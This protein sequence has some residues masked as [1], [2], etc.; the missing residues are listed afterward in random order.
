MIFENIYLLPF[1]YVMLASF[2][3]GFFGILIAAKVLS[4]RNPEL[5]QASGRKKVR[6]AALFGGVTSSFFLS[7]VICTITPSVITIENDLNHTEKFSF[8][9]NGEFLGVGGTYIA[10]NSSTKLKL[11][12]VGEDKGMNVV[13]PPHKIK[14]ITKSPEVYFKSVPE[15]YR[16]RVTTSRGKRKVI[17]G[18]TVYLVKY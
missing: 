1:L 11:V 3:V 14:K 15:N 6:L 18:P 17:S 5:P 9:S 2:A 4:K 7:I 8:F 13:I 16:V 10:N 12:G